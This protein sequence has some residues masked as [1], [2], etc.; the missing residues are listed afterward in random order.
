MPH[1]RPSIQARDSSGRQVSLLNDDYPPSSPRSPVFLQQL[2]HPANR[3]FAKQGRSNSYA[4]IRSAPPSPSTPDL[5]RSHSYDSQATQ[6]P[7]SPITPTSILEFGRLPY[8]SV[9]PSHFAPPS[10]EHAEK[11]PTPYH[12]YAPNFQ[13]PMITGRPSYSSDLS[14]RDEGS[15][16]PGNN[17]GNSLEKGTK[18]YPCRFRESHGCEKTF[19][20]SG[21]AS[22]HSKIHT[23]EKAVHCSFAGCHKKFTRADNMKQHLETHYKGRSRSA[24]QSSSKSTLTVAAGVKKSTA[25]DR[26]SRSPSRLGKP[27]NLKI[28]LRS[29]SQYSSDAYPV[30]IQGTHSGASTPVSPYSSMDMTRIQHA[31][32]SH[33]AAMGTEK[34]SAGLDVLA[35]AVACQ[36]Q[37]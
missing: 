1:S 10:Y 25:T 22:R 36:S 33:Q 4:S 35:L 6:D 30:V 8:P 24:A 14:A 9:P 11:A 18:R 16:A 34:V 15:T 32:M 29:Q 17:G 21:H 37:S 31:L 26:S 23:A 13:R 27:E 5:L 19:T 12:D 28:D 2:P 7:I 3:E 20:T